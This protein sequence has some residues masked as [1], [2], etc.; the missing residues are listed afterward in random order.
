VELKFSGTCNYSSSWKT[1]NSGV[2]QG[3]VL[4]PLL[5]NTY[6]NDF[7][8]LANNSSNVIKYADDTSILIASNCYEELNR[9]FN[10][11]LYNTLTWF[12]A[13][14]LVLYGKD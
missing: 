6:I 11:V 2:P 7:P 10:V 8:D 1:V 13:N 12:Q 14:Q 3:L 5:F 9:N 4:G